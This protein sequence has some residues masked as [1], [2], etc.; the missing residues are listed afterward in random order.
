MKGPLAYMLS[1][2]RTSQ[3]TIL[4]GQDGDAI[5]TC[6]THSLLRRLG[7]PSSRSAHVTMHSIHYYSCSRH[8][9][10]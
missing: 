3:E 1:G 2:R 7:F 5:V 8:R 4:H 10:T 9:G 6:Q